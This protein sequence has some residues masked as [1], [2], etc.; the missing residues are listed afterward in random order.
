MG[1]HLLYLPSKH[2]S[3]HLLRSNDKYLLVPRHMHRH[4]KWVDTKFVAQKCYH[5]FVTINDTY[6]L[7]ARNIHRLLT[8]EV[9][10]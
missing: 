10:D 3:Q 9:H 4:S 6:L 5:K 8:L 2:L 7:V 1:Q